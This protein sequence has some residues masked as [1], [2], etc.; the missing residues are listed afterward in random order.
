[1]SEREL[2]DMNE[3]LL[4]SSVR[5]HELTEEAWDSMLDIN[6]KGAWLGIKAALP[7]LRRRKG[8]IVNVRGTGL[9]PV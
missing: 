9:K 2:R 8:T 6:L 7:L 4:I 3:A 1:M 5:Q